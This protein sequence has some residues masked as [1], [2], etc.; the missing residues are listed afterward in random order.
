MG[1]FYITT[2]IYYV[3]DVPHI[4]HAYTTIAADV[5][6]RYHRQ[7]GDDVFFLT[8]TD[9]HGQKN[10]Q[11]AEAKGIT[12]QSHV[13]AVSAEFRRL[14]ERLHIAYDDFIRTTSERH[15]KGVQAF[16]YR[17]VASESSVYRGTYAGWYCTACEAFYADEDLLAG[18]VCPIHGR[19]VEW[20]EEE[21][22]F[23]ALS[24]YQDLLYDLVANTDFVQPEGARQELLGL[25]HQG[26]KDFSLT[27]QHVRWGIPVPDDPEHVVYVWADAL[28]NYI[29][30]LDF[31]DDSEQFRRYW[32]ADVHLIG[33]E[34]VRFHCLYW[35]AMLLA[36]DVPLPRRVFAHGWLT[37]DDRKLSKT[38]GNVIDPNALIDQFGADAVRYFFLRE[39]RFGRDWNYTD[40]AFVGRYNADLANDLGNLLHRT[41]HMLRRYTHGAVPPPAEY[42]AAE[43]TLRTEV[44][45]LPGRVEAAMDSFAFRDALVAIWDLVAATNRYVEESAPWVLA[46]WRRDGDS[47]ATERLD[48]V[49]YTLA[50]TLV[51]I[52]CSLAPF[53]PAT[54]EKIVVRLGQEPGVLASPPTVNACRP[55]AMVTVGEPLFPKDKITI[56]AVA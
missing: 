51:A 38:T 23:F 37:K 52:A 15:R 49:L 29:T 14:W 31:A 35:P 17:L 42:R 28:T 39:G 19:P 6:S 24:R 26:L 44:S 47:V 43:L 8:G 55:G 22:Y 48:T 16:W 21:N 53:V 13:D 36:V 27:R 32:P 54:A 25:L 5:M 34:I 18:A 20:T 50:D 4:G 12:P 45:A 3:N 7:R 40:A 30:A 1:T 33:K 41:T 2:P 10:A 9:E 11:V 46:R 56:G